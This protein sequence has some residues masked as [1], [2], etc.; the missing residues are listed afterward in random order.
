[1]SIESLMPS[2]HLIL[3]RPLLL[4]PSIFP[5]FRLFSNESAVRIRRPKYW[6]F[7]VSP[8]NEYSR[9]ISLVMTG[10]ISLLSKGL[11]RVFSPVRKHQFFGAQ[12]LSSPDYCPETETRVTC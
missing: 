8:F 12:V 6:S 9:L 11:S 10:W 3:C 4:L 7:S 1:M 2:D 5:S